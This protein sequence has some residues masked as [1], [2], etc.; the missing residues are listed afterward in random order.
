MLDK[1][2]I[3]AKMKKKEKRNKW[4][5]CKFKTKPSKRCA[6]SQR[7]TIITTVTTGFLALG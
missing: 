6:S 1:Q 7:P 4:L 5:K 2:A 3:K